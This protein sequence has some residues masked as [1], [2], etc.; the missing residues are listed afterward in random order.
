MKPLN[1]EEVE[2]DLGPILV[3][4]DDLVITPIIRA[5]GTWEPELGQILRE[6]LGPGMTA[7]DVGGN[8][9][10]V[11][12]LLA[13][14]VGPGGRVVAV[15]PDPRNAEALR[16]NAERTRGAPIEV[17]E[18]AAW[19]EP[20]E[21]ELELH[22]S[23]TGDHR[24]GLEDAGREKVSVP[25]VRLDDVLPDSVDLILM[26]T[27]ATEHVALAGAEELLRRARPVL[28]IEFWP[29][30]IREGGGEPRAVLDGYR[31]LGLRLSGAEGELPTD[32]GELV[33]AVESSEVPFTTLRLDPV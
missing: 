30:G 9:G 6:E 25:A 18:A 29:A 5:H 7:V 24:V 2:T 21:V 27:Q 26:D 4:A 11:A 28:F 3:H 31:D 14:A 33:A 1:L 23:N 10:Y 22:D 16:R 32:H 20:G 17:I 15:E 8:I 12:L 19:S 13:E